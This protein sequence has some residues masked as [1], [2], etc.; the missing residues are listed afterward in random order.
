LAKQFF[1]NYGT[2]IT[3]VVSDQSHFTVA[4]GVL[5]RTSSALIIGPGIPWSAGIEFTDPV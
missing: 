3:K 2:G 5:I 1:G 4:N